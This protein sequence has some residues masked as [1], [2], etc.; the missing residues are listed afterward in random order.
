MN[1]VLQFLGLCA[2]GRH[3]QSGA[4]SVEKNVKRHRAALVVVAED[5]SENTKK[6]FRDMCSYYHTDLRI[7][8]S[9]IS[10]GHAIGQEMRA[11]VCVTDRKMAEALCQKIDAESTTE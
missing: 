3:V 1:R 6:D 5:A 2:R 10:I 11:V 8:G 9:K 4:F 7:Y